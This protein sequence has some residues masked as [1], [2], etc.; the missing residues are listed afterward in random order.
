MQHQKRALSQILVVNAFPAAVKCTLQSD[1]NSVT[2]VCTLRNYDHKISKN[3][4]YVYYFEIKCRLF[5]RV[6]AN[7]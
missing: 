7:A 1:D 4:N 2:Q 5:Y 6:V 3:F